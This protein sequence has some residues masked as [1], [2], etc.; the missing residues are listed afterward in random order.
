M[1]PRQQVSR[2]LYFQHYSALSTNSPGAT[3]TDSPSEAWLVVPKFGKHQNHKAFVTDFT[4]QAKV[5]NGASDLLVELFGP[6]AAHTRS[7]VGVA[8]LP[9]GV[10]VE[11]NMIV[12]FD[13]AAC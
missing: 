5:L 3:L 11:V 4:D 8:S 7:A 9:L 12:E 2:L 1:E 13:P 6:A 10:A